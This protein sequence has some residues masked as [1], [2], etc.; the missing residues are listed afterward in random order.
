MHIYMHGFI[1]V[2]DATNVFLHAQ[3][4]RF[5]FLYL[6]DIDVLRYICIVDNYIVCVCVLRFAVRI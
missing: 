5:L 4:S 2:C 3:A 1:A 6:Y